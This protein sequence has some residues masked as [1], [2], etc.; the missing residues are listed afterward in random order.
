MFSSES[1]P[2]VIHQ[3]IHK[4]QLP[5]QYGGTAPEPQVYW[6]PTMPKFEPGE[7][8]GTEQVPVVPR[9]EYVTYWK[10]NQVL[11]PMPL[12]MRR[13]L[14]PLPIDKV[15]EQPLQVSSNQ[16]RQELN[17]HVKGAASPMVQEMF[18]DNQI[19]TNPKETS[20]AVLGMRHPKREEKHVVVSNLQTEND[21]SF[22]M[23]NEADI[24]DEKQPEPGAQS[25]KAQEHQE[26]LKSYS[27]R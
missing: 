12:E 6:P 27:L 18:S 20:P 10:Q 19:N 3:H 23:I 26:L 14:E 21:S 25:R 1:A 9:S 15:A 13:D 5:V 24:N 8:L 17:S 16:Q 22:W 4:S 2:E 11:T 7:T